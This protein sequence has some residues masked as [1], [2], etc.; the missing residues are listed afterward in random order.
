MKR[1]MSL[2]DVVRPLEAELRRALEDLFV[3][4][5]LD[6]AQ[7]TSKAICSER[8]LRMLKIIAGK[9]RIVSDYDFPHSVVNRTGFHFKIIRKDLNMPEFAPDAGVAP[10]H[11]K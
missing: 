9:F 8:L 6:K 1:K 7:A 11:Q 5:G 10:G 2:R 3:I 4:R